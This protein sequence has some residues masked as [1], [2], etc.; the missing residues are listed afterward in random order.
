MQI[1]SS[2]ARFSDQR[3]TYEF[4]ARVLEAV[5]RV[6]GVASAALTS[7]LPLSGDVDLY[8]VHFDPRPSDDPGEVR[9]TFRYAVSPSYLETMRIPLRRGRLL[10]EHDR[11]GTPRVALISESMARRRLPGLDPIGRRFQIGDGPLVTVV[12]IVSDVRQLSLALNQPDAVY[13]PADQWRFADNAMSLVV[14]TRGDPTGLA[15]AVRAAVWSVDKDQ[16]V[17]RVATMTDLLVASAGARRFALILFE[18]FALTALVLAAAGIYGVLS[19][20]V[21]ERTREIGIRA[22]LGAS[23]QDILALVVRQGMTV[24]LAGIV[25]GLAGAFVASQAIASLLFGVSALD[26]ITYA[27]VLAL[28]LIASL[29]ACSVPAWRAA[30][31]DP[32][33]TLRAE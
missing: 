8:G 7:Q 17:V 13:I 15:P 12:G 23:R 16:P 32:A 25:A 20:S 14:R 22:A 27:G 30:R 18:A 24:T 6:P 9:G 11:A 2:T 26:A 21:A 1:Q 10:N 31:V 4:F 28:L 19:G 29:L 33:L 5:R 3:A